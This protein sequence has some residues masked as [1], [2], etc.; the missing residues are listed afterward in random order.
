M[1]KPYATEEQAAVAA[2]R[3]AC[4]LTASVFNK[5]VRNE[6]LTKGDKSPVTG[7]ECIC[8]MESRVWHGAT[9][10]DFAAQAVISSILQHAFPKDAIVGEEDASD[11]RVESG[12]E[13]KERIVDL[14]NEA[15]TLDLALGDSDT[16]GIGPGQQ[17]SAEEIL[18]AID[19]G[20]FEGGNSGS[21]WNAFLGHR[22][23]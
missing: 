16:W 13:M 17:K 15:L 20:N 18:D 5:L 3:R 12:K 2:V 22:W 11:L 10:G 23:S 21:T 7:E 14:A 9:V 1:S 4:H 6:T 19:R 8:R